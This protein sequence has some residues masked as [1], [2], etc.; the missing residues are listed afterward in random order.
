MLTMRQKRALRPARGF[1]AFTAALSLGL[2]LA[3]AGTLLVLVERA[4][5]PLAAILAFGALA[6]IGDRVEAARAPR[7]SSPS[8]PDIEPLLQRLCM[9]AGLPAPE[10]VSEPYAIAIAWT[11][12]GRIHV[13]TGLRALLDDR[14]LEAV[15]AHELAHLARRD[16]AVIELCAA[17]SGV[18]MGYASLVQSLSRPS[19]SGFS[20]LTGLALWVLALVCVPPALAVAW[21]SRLFVLGASRAREHAADTAAAALTGRPSALASALL[22][23]E[24]DGGWAPRD[25]LRA[26]AA[27]AILC[28]VGTSRPR[29]GRLLSTHP[30]TAER[31]RRLERLEVQLH[32][33]AA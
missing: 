17:P 5:I 33:G 6:A 7:W 31:V 2:P 13:T 11:S 23:I 24:A 19:L 12:R 26:G 28:I 20:S 3:V 18:L 9:R 21:L 8:P 15:L 30:P 4:W 25:D 1:G 27:P 32:A 14:E 16:A 22:K 29:L 10:L